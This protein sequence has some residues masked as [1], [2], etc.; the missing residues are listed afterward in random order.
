MSWSHFQWVGATLLLAIFILGVG[1]NAWCMI[2]WRKKPARGHVS[3]AP[4]IAGIAGVVGILLL[5]VGSI[6][7]RLSLAWLP[8]VLDPGSGFFFVGA[9]Y[10]YYREKR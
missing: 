9:I 4:L 1:F 3:P 10:S 2:E 6:M 7:H 5:P 8:L